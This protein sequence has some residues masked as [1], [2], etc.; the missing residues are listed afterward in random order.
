MLVADQNTITAI[1]AKHWSKTR[2]AVEGKIADLRDLLVEADNLRLQ[3]LHELSTVL[4]PVQ[5]A[6]CIIAAFELGYAI[7]TLKG[8]LSKGNI[9]FDG[10]IEKTCLSE[11]DLLKG[12]E[13]SRFQ[14]KGSNISGM[15]CRGS[16]DKHESFQKVSATDIFCL[17]SD[18][19]SVSAT[20]EQL[21]MCRTPRP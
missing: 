4:D 6:K 20:Y 5:A 8:S 19:K 21:Q 7:K 17:E 1:N 9:R 10:M 18:A 15:G 2:A 12:R 14:A 16:T 11:E 13:T 3:T